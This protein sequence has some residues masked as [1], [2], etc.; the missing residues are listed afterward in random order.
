MKI[1]NGFVS[2]S[3]S[4]SFIIAL[5]KK[6][7]SVEE[8]MQVFYPK[9]IG[10]KCNWYDDIVPKEVASEK[11]FAQL[12]NQEPLKEED[13]LDEILAG[14]F[15]GYPDNS[16]YCEDAEK[17]RSAF[18][19]KTGKDIYEDRNSLEFKQY[20]K[21]L[22]EHIDRKHK[23]IDIAARRYFNNSKEL[24]DNKQVFVVSFSDNDGEVNAILEHGTTF[25]NVPH[26]IISH[27]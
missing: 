18:Q 3:S 20:S 6:P 10:V 2:N 8:T 19:R 13:I 17:I 26:I 16:F 12:V 15:P 9:A 1:R 25:K 24:F 27:H 23:Q 22:G 21:V 14:Y 11:I 4:S 7:E 5:D